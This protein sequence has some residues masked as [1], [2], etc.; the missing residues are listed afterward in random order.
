LTYQSLI[1]YIVITIIS[2]HWKK[3]LVSSRCCLEWIVYWHADVWY[4]FNNSCVSASGM[5]FNSAVQ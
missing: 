5:A 3:I 4:V 2:L 1:E